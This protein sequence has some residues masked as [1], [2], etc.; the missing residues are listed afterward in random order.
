ML[1]ASGPTGA[2][3]M[4]TNSGASSAE[5]ADAIRMT[6]N[7][8]TFNLLSGSAI[9]GDIYFDRPTLPPSTSARA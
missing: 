7:D 9:Q 2:D 8:A 5:Q 3:A 6:A 1:G 4:I